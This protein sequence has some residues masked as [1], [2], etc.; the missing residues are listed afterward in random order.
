MSQNLTVF[1][2]L[3]FAVLL[4]AGGAY[5]GYRVG[6]DRATLEAKVQIAES[7]T[8]AAAAAPAKR[9]GEEA[10]DGEGAKSKKDKPEFEPT[11]LT[12]E[13]LVTYVPS[14]A[15]LSGDSEAKALY[16]MNNVVG[17]CVPCFEQQYSLGKCLQREAKLLD[18]TLCADVKTV[19]NRVVRLAK[20]NKSPDEIK[21][22]TEFSQPWVPIDTA[23]R[24]S[25]GPADAPITLIEYSDFQCPY[26]KKA[27]PNIKAVEEKYAGKLRIVFMNEPLPTFRESSGNTTTRCL[28]RRA[29]TKKSWC[30]W[31][32]TLG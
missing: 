13:E 28:R 14:L 9:G 22:Q 29:W 24:P 30:K 12:K 19:A 27:Q 21:E 5:G 8:A 17:A 18:K 31:L 6:Y 7:A 26:C 23:G 16:V 15:S 1:G 20:A 4:G 32:K 11:T 10:D 2:L 25:K 3:G